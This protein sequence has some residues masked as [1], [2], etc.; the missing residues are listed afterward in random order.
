VAAV[1]FVVLLI[2]AGFLT[3]RLLGVRDWRCYAAAATWAPILFALQTANVTLLLALGLVVLWRVR[4]R[5]GHAA[6]VAALLITLKLF[7]WPLTIWVAVRHG[8]RRG[9]LCML[10][11][12]CLMLAGWASL[13]F[14]GLTRYPHLVRTSSTRGDRRRTAS[15]PSVCA[16]GLTPTVA[17]LLLIAVGGTVL[18]GGIARERRGCDEAA[19]TMFIVVAVRHGLRRGVLCMLGFVWL[20]PLMLWLYPNGLGGPSWYPLALLVA[21]TMVLAIASLPERPPKGQAALPVRRW[22]PD[23]RASQDPA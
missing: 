10:G 16:S 7:L 8:L 14:G 17:D 5:P 15:S 22:R 6:G 1:L 23:W 2:C 12:V 20:A 3:L 13:G 4:D 18:L 11:C 19:F 21:G 9:V